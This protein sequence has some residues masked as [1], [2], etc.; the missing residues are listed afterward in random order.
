MKSMIAIFIALASINAFA[1]DMTV[2]SCED[3]SVSLN[4]VYSM[5]TYANGSIKV[6]EIDMIEPAAAPVGV[7]IAI[8][9]G[10]GLADWESFCRFVPGLS[11]VN[12]TKSKASYDKSSNVLTLTMN[13]SQTNVDGVSTVKILTI[14]IN[15]GAASE[16]NLVKASLK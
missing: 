8:D 12:V 4:S 2:T 14:V 13:A 3:Y 15:K 9:R 1:M 7:A 16:E 10:T 6:F 5:K 11:S